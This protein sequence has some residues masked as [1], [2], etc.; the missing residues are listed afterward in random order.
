ML[1]L[2]LFTSTFELHFVW[3]GLRNYLFKGIEWIIVWCI[4]LSWGRVVSIATRLRSG[5]CS[6]LS[7]CRV[8]GITTRLRSGR[9]IALSR[10][11]VVSITT[12]LRSGRCIAFSRCRVVGIT[13]SLRS[14]RCIVLNRCGV[15]SIP[16]RLQNGR[17]WFRIPACTLYPKRRDLFWDPPRLL[18]SG[19]RRIFPG[20]GK[21]CGWS[22]TSSSAKVKDGFTTLFPLYAF[23]TWSYICILQYIFPPSKWIPRFLMDLESQTAFG[24]TSVMQIALTMAR[25]E[26]NL[27]DHVTC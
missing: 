14:G 11:R 6:A 8:V 25:S 2:L 15:V 17:S 16:T 18:F 12:R 10:C 21:A 27:M 24:E 19:Y 1:G 9:C 23:M 3:N 5:R 4:A 22:L 7:R 13:T 26:G 20:G